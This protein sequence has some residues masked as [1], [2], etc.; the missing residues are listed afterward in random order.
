[1]KRETETGKEI[2]EI[3]LPV[4]ITI[5]KTENEP[6]YAS[7]RGIMMAKK[8]PVETKDVS[9]IG[10]TFIVDEMNLPKAKEP[11][12]IVG[13]DAS[14]TGELASLLHNEAKVI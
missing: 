13:E 8:K 6:R 12:K 7:L 4:L 3:D 5:D 9:L 10:N 11:C 2:F 14:N 1:M